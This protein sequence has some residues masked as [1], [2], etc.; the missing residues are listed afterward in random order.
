MLSMFQSILHLQKFIN[1]FLTEFNV[2]ESEG[3]I[4]RDVVVNFL[5]RQ[6]DPVKVRATV[7]KCLRPAGATPEDKAYNYIRC[8]FKNIT[9]KI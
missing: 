3:V 6:Y 4:N 7:D 8:F 9:Y 2:W 1:C 5:G